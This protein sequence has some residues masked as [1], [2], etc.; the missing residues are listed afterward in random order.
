MGDQEPPALAVWQP[1]SLPLPFPAKADPAGLALALSF[2]SPP[3]SAVIRG[4]QLLI[5]PADSVSGGIRQGMLVRGRER[6]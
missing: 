5:I 2:V 1:L 3:A 4:A 6:V